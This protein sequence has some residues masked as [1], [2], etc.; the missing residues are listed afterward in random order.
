MLFAKVS[1]IALYIVGLFLY[2]I[3][4]MKNDVL[5]N[6][7]YILLIISHVESQF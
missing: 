3:S 4:S 2:S 5:K 1:I 7:Q 6:C